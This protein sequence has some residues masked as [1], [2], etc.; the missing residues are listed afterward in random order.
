MNC[1]SLV[2]SMGSGDL[3]AVV[4]ELESTFSVSSDKTFVGSSPP[5]V[6]GVSRFMRSLSFGVLDSSHESLLVRSSDLGGVLEY[7][8]FMSTDVLGV[9]DSG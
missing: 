8:V 4:L 3:G 9:V 7:F 2:V 5:S 6:V 1:S